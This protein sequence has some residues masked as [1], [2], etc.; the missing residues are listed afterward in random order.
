MR[1]PIFDAIRTALGRGIQPGEVADIDLLLDRLGIGRDGLVPGKAAL[2]LIKSFEG[3]RLTAYP[4]PG[5]GGDPW[6]VGWGSTGA[7]I[8]SGVTWTQAQADERFAVDVA[9]FGRGVADAIGDAPTTQMQFDAMISLAYNIGLGA[10]VGST[11]LRKHKAGD[12]KGA[13]AQ[14]GAWVKAGGK[15]M[16]G[17]VRRRE[18][19]MRVYMGLGL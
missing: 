15:T 8:H 9:R 10:F 11:L 2:D 4:D 5:S 12:Y 17:L 1:K 13:A 3:C 6:T 18:A 16:K 14:F 19:E 7:G